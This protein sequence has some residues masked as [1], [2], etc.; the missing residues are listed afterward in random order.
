[1]ERFL[2]IKHIVPIELYVLSDLEDSLP[3]DE[4][5]Q[6]SESFVRCCDRLVIDRQEFFRDLNFDDGRPLTDCDRR[7]HLHSVAADVL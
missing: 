5:V 1:M 6:G 2:A 3:D 7:F 4:L